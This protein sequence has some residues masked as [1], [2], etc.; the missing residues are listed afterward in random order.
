MKKIVSA[1]LFIAFTFIFAQAQ[2]TSY[3][4]YQGNQVKEC[5]SYD[6]LQ[7]NSGVNIPKYIVNMDLSYKERWREIITNYK[8]PIQVFINYLESSDAVRKFEQA[9]PLYSDP[10]FLSELQAISDLANVTFSGIQLVSQMYEILGAVGCTSILARSPDGS[11]VH[12][13]N[14][15]YNYSQLISPLLANIEFQRNGKTVFFADMIIGTA[16]VVT[17]V[18]PNGFSITINQRDSDQQSINYLM[19][20]YIPACY[21][22]YQVLQTNT[23]YQDALNTLL[24][25][26]I[27]MPAYLNIA[28]VSGNQ[29]SVIERDREGV[30]LQTTLSGS[31]WFICQTNY[32]RSQI[33]PQS[34]YRRV[35]CEQKF[36]LLNQNSWKPQDMFN[37]LSQSPNYVSSTITTDIMIPK[38]GYINSTRWFNPPPIKQQVQKLYKQILIVAIE[39]IFICFL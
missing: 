35:P 26:K 6:S 11:I 4:V 15:D 20:Q 27:A 34:D 3:C 33:D 29:A 1:N 12:G 2:Q 5:A 30:N 32:D 38:T 8:S 39:L 9:F 17:G 7:Q 18:V 19:Q 36:G 25:T 14:L 21:L 37:I 22:I 31:T 28:G 13:R 23:T 24:N 10:N 16:I